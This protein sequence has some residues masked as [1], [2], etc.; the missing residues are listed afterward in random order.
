[1]FDVQFLVVQPVGV[2]GCENDQNVH[3]ARERFLKRDY[4]GVP[5]V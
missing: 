1:M 5:L 4:S 3:L 2:A